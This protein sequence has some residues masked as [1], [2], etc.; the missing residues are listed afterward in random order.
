VRSGRK[1]GTQLVELSVDKE[2]CT[3]AVTRGPERGKLKIFLGK[4]LCQ[5][6]ASGQ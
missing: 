5:E 6:T 1:H 2:F 4:N 3:A